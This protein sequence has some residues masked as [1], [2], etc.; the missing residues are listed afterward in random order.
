MPSRLLWHRPLP[1]AL[2]AAVLW[3]AALVPA[4]AAPAEPWAETLRR[5]DALRAAL[6]AGPAAAAARGLPAYS[7]KTGDDGPAQRVHLAVLGPEGPVED[8]ALPEDD[9]EEEDGAKA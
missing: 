4:R 5:V 1:L 2:L 7:R 6:A 3:V 8:A 9:E